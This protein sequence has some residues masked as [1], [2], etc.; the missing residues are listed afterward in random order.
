MNFIFRKAR[1]LIV[2]DQRI[3]A[4]DLAT[5]IRKIGHESVGIESKGEKAISAVENLKP[6]LVFMD[7]SLAGEMDGIETASI[8]RKNFGIPVIYI[9][10][11]YDQ[12]TI[13]KSMTTNAY[14]YLVKPVDDCSINAIINAAIYRYDSEILSV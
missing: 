4:L 5:T 2:E 3:I 9:S 14:G 12:N 13:E 6:D 7:I 11:N 8:I 10:G 1:V